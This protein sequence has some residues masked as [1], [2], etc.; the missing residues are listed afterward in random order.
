MNATSEILLEADHVSRAYGTERIL[1]DVFLTI[2]AGTSTSIIGPSGSGKT[3]LLALLSLLLDP[4]SGHIRVNGRDAAELPD[5]ERSR[6]RNQ[7][8]GNVFQAAHLVG[9]LSVLE[10]VLV[11][12][13]LTGHV[14]EKRREALEWIERLGLNAR[15][16]HLP[17]MLSLGQKRRVSLARALIM[18]PSI[19]LADEPTNDLDPRR[20]AQVSEFLLGLPKEGYALIL[21]THD[22]DLAARAQDRLQLSGGVLTPWNSFST[23]CMKSIV[24]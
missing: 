22:A 19:V 5:W 16:N 11:P 1:T 6:L 4:T 14:R 20:V 10:N 8:Y 17:H 9:S 18:R 3:T 7:F 12:A 23:R 24:K 13:F 15:K 2:R 21:V